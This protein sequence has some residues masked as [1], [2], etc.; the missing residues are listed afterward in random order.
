MT[1]T[2]A[3]YT[4]DEVIPAPDNKMVDRE[5][6]NI[7]LAWREIKKALGPD[8]YNYAERVVNALRDD[9]RH[10]LSFKD[11]DHLTQKELIQI[12][13]IAAPYGGWLQAV[14]ERALVL[15]KANPEFFEA[16]LDF[17][18]LEKEI[19]KIAELADKMGLEEYS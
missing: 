2:E 17:E 9:G 14:W 3:I 5:H 1:L 16:L 12:V 7:A 19:A 13:C 10:S 11:V 8:N 15:Y 6:L 4:L 18:D